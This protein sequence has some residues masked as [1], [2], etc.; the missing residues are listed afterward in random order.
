MNEEKPIGAEIRHT[1]NLIKA[2]IDQTLENHLKENLT[3]IEGMTMGYIFRHQDQEITAKEV[4]ARSRVSKATTSQTLNGL[5]KK[6]YIRMSPSKTDKRKKVI[7]LT[8]K[9]EQVEAEFNEIFK[10]I[11]ARVKKGITPEE[12]A[13]VRGILAKIRANVGG[14]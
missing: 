13:T 14:E 1:D 10:E 6:G 8:A 7:T 3:G 5:V 2:Y 12:E 4:M 11:S 9:G